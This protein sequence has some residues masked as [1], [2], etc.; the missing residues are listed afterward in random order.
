MSV[1]SLF[2][3]KDIAIIKELIKP[4][5]CHLNAA[6]VAIL[7]DAE[8]LEGECL[9]DGEY[10]PHAFNR[11]D[12]KIFDFTLDGQDIGYSLEREYSAKQI[13]D[14]F[15]TENLSFITYKGALMPD[16]YFYYD[17]EGNRKKDDNNKDVKAPIYKLIYL[18]RDNTK[19]GNITQTID[20]IYK[21][22]DR[23]NLDH[24]SKVWEKS[25]R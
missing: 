20:Y 2:S 13:A 17:K 21:Y 7:L 5:E 11:I 10:F 25:G 3:K 14:I 12:G 23:L 15:R 19:E 22:K 6:L 8:Y 24:N 9:L 1:D 4:K 16:G 18:L